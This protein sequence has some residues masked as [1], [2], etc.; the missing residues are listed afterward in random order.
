M[1]K[2]T[3]FKSFACTIDNNPEE[4]SCAQ[5]NAWIDRN[6]LV[7]VVDWNSVL[8]DGSGYVFIITV[9]YTGEETAP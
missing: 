1:S 9:Q 5:L 4:H 6:P 2:P 7:E 8:A 3:H